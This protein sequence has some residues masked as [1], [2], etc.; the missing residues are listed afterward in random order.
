MGGTNDNYKGK[1]TW[2]STDTRTFYGALNALITE[3]LKAYPGKPILF[4]T[5]IQKP[6]SYKSNTENP[7]KT[8]LDKTLGADLT[9]EDRALCIKM[10][11]EQYGVTCLDLYHCSGI[12]GVD[13]E[14]IYYKNDL[15]HP[16]HLAQ[17]RLANLIQDKLE[18]YWK[19]K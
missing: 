8:L 12:N 1:G 10:K 18:V 15:L 2:D 4:C 19:E 9:M 7:L 17:E 14:T 6:D 11:C 5:M 3:L 16:S 13:S